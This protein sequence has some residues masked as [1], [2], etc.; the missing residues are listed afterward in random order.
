MQNTGDGI[1]IAGY[2]T[3]VVGAPVVGV[4]AAPGATI[5]AVGN[6]IALA[7]SGLE[8]VTN[9]IAGDNKAAGQ[10]A[11]FVTGGLVIA[12]FV[13]R[14]LPGP[15]PNISEEATIILKE[16]INVKGIIAEDVIKN[17]LEEKK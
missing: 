5:A 6:G 12:A 17:K 11:A 7:G 10:E 8:I 15:T 9:L 16:N 3:A 4:G 1:A 14:A 13:D 2:A